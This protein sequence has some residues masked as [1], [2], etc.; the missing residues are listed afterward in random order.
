MPKFFNILSRAEI[1][2]LF[3]TLRIQLATQLPT[4]QDFGADFRDDLQQSALKSNVS[5]KV[6]IVT[7]G[8]PKVKSRS[9]I[10]KLHP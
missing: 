7:F 5:T 8:S 9:R 3:K 10:L 1:L 2:K 6:N 4:L